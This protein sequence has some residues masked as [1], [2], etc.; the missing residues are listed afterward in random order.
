MYFPR[1]T[2]MNRNV[3][4]AVIAM[5]FV[6]LTAIGSGNAKAQYF[7]YS[8]GYG[9]PVVSY[10]PGYAVAP[11]PVYAAP[12][13]VAYPVPVPTPVVVARPAIPVPVVRPYPVYRPVVRPVIRALR[14]YPY[15]RLR[16]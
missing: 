7:S 8:V 6:A 1:E 15:L 9:A 4:G 3:Y 12:A 2:Q 11:A 13:P 14:P 16:Y 5:A 10:S